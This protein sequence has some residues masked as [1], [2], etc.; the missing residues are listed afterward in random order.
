MNLPK[1]LHASGVGLR[2]YP[3]MELHLTR[4]SNRSH[5]EPRKSGASRRQAEK[6][7]E[8]DIACKTLVKRIFQYNVSP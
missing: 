8:F 6:T 7:P 5:W 3:T 2:T 4:S 1:D